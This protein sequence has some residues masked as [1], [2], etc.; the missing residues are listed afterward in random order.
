MQKHTHVHA[1]SK[2]EITRTTRST[3]KI[4]LCTA[5]QHA[6][7]FSY[8]SSAATVLHFYGLLSRQCEN[9]EQSSKEKL[10]K[11]LKTGASNY[12]EKWYYS[13]LRHRMH[14]DVKGDEAE[15]VSGDS[16][17]QLTTGL[18]EHLELPQ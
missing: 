12:F 18:D 13:R 4:G 17:L 7:Y 5:T 1:H 10:S 14:Q 3:V 2:L 8:S 6:T 16:C 11:G 15:V 9:V